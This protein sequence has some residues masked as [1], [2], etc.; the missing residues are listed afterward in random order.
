LRPLRP[1]IVRRGSRTRSVRDARIPAQVTGEPAAFQPWFTDRAIVDHRSCLAANW[2]RGLEL[3][4]RLLD[5]GVV[6][7]HEKFFVSMAHTDE[8]IELT[9]EAE[10]K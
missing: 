5:A 8:D 9:L 10:T 6:K 4:D 3:V 2:Q 7:A 1:A